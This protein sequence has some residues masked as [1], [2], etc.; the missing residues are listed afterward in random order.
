MSDLD[1]DLSRSRVDAFIEALKTVFKIQ[2]GRGSDTALAL[3]FG[4][5]RQDIQNWRQRGQ[6]PPKFLK[7]SLSE[8][9]VRN[10]YKIALKLETPDFDKGHT[11]TTG[12]DLLMV[13]RTIAE[14]LGDGPG[15]TEGMRAEL[16]GLALDELR[17]LRAEGR[18]NKFRRR[19]ERLVSYSRKLAERALA[20]VS[21][22]SAKSD[23]AVKPKP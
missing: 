1:S 4:K 17:E 5:T 10:V 11:E 18:E 20:P 19:L 2:P 13:Q 15:F 8:N 21:P 12:E 16:C 9:D 7:E 23:P 22:A 3:K 14:L 6:I